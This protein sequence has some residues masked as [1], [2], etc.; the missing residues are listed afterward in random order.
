MLPVNIDLSFNP[1]VI[2]V[3]LG[4]CII[5]VLVSLDL[6]RRGRAA[7]KLALIG[8]SVVAIITYQAAMAVPGVGIMLPVYLP[9]ILA[10]FCGLVLAKGYYTAPALAY[11]SGSMGTLLG[12]DIFS[13][14]TPGVLPA[15]SPPMGQRTMILSIGGAGVFDGI[16]LTGVLAVFLAAVTVCIFRRS[17]CGK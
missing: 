13:L 15:L 1:V 5:P 14:L 17:G 11:I 6:L 7:L 10:A 8:A 12:A 3:N 16:F 4:G 2:A 9:P